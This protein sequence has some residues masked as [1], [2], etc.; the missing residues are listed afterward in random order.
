MKGRLLKILI[1]L[2]GVTQ[3]SEKAYG[4][5]PWASAQQGYIEQAFI[6]ANTQTPMTRMTLVSLKT[7]RP[8]PPISGRIKVTS[9]SLEDNIR[10]TSFLNK[11]PSLISF[12]LHSIETGSTTKVKASV[13]VSIEHQVLVSKAMIPRGKH[14]L[15][16]QVSHQW[17]PKT[18]GRG[19]IVQDIEAIK[20]LVAKSSIKPGT[21][22]RDQLF[23]RPITV[24]RGSLVPFVLKQN[25]ITLRG[26][27]KALEN[28]YKEQVFN[29]LLPNTKKQLT[30]QVVRHDLVRIVQ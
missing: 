19:L 30:A 21:I 23:T 20:D 4:T 5:T 8:I 22:L 15:E 2:L 26:Q 24:K 14:I 28:G 6:T 29:V 10:Q 12:T 3:F 11:L 18:R 16:H 7:L 9:S 13:T 17:I 1:F 27:V 25:G